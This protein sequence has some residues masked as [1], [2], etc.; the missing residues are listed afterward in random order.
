MS[1]LE[2]CHSCGA[3]VADLG[4]LAARDALIKANTTKADADPEGF[5]P[6][7]QDGSV[8]EL[9]GLIVGYDIGAMRGLEFARL[10]EVM[11]RWIPAIEDAADGSGTY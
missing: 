9:R 10:V 6:L 2:P 3:S 4:L 5:K 1:T 11:R 8:D 7:I